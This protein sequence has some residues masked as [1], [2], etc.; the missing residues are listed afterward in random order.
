MPIDVSVG[1]EK[2]LPLL[3]EYYNE[4]AILQAEIP[5]HSIPGVKG[6]CLCI[7]HLITGKPVS[8]SIQGQ[9]G[10]RQSMPLETVVLADKKRG[11]FEW[12][13][14]PIQQPQSSQPSRSVALQPTSPMNKDTIPIRLR[15]LDIAWL[16]SMPRQKQLVLRWIFNFIDDR[17]SVAEI[18]AQFPYLSEEMIEQALIFLM[19]THFITIGKREHQT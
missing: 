2:A 19:A 12:V 4:D 18:K 11:P 17:R 14:L 9:G 3:A 15:P 6:R 8:C 1:L 10:V 16:T 13:L 7:I 5:R